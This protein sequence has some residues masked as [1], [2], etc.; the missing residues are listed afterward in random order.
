MTPAMARMEASW[1]TA[2]PPMASPIPHRFVAEASAGPSPGTG[3]MKRSV[4]SLRGVPPSTGFTTGGGNGRP[5]R[6]VVSVA[7]A[8][9]ELSTLTSDASDSASPVETTSPSR[10]SD[11]P[12]SSGRPSSKGRR[13]ARLRRRELFDATGQGYPDTRHGPI[14]ATHPRRSPVQP[15]PN[16]NRHAATVRTCAGVAPVRRAPRR[17]QPRSPTSTGHPRCGLTTSQ[18]RITPRPTTFAP[19]TPTDSPH[20]RAGRWPTGVAPPGRRRCG[21]WGPARHSPAESDPQIG[22]TRAGSVRIPLGWEHES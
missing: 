18:P 14:W 22:A 21:T 6:R 5:G 16:S 15:S 8:V 4:N 19:P 10:A 13:V 1:A 12:V 9:A 11:A 3:A 2:Q 17:H 20:R 7:T